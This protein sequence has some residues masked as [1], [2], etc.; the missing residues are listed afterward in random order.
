LSFEIFQ[1]F[2]RG[3]SAADFSLPSAG[4][5]KKDSK[6]DIPQGMEFLLQNKNKI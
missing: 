5:K 2:K 3:F 1:I 4:L 6:V